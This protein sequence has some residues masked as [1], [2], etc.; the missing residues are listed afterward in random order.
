MTH[1]KTEMKKLCGSES[2]EI[3]NIKMEVT[4]TCSD[5]KT[6][7]TLEEAQA[8]EKMICSPEMRINKL[9]EKVL[10]L[11]GKI[12]ILESKIS[13]LEDRNKFFPQ[14]QPIVKYPD[15]QPLPAE[16]GQVKWTYFGE[17]HPDCAHIQDGHADVGPSYTV[18]NP[19]ELSKLTDEELL[20]KGYTVVYA[21]HKRAITPPV[22][23]F[24]FD[25]VATNPLDNSDSDLKDITKNKIS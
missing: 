5:G 25:N 1:S 11:E 22:T 23:S 14:Q 6:F 17:K 4:Y 16:P 18:Y 9:E 7:N 24:D 21:G 3:S 2:L 12:S 19:V 15:S 10:E 13:L 8:Y 20:K